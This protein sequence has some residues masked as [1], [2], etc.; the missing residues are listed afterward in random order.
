M[1]TKF[2]R[3]VHTARISHL[4]SQVTF[5]S[6]GVVR[7]CG[8]LDMSK[9]QKTC[10]KKCKKIFFAKRLLKSKTFQALKPFF[11]KLFSKKCL[12]K[13]FY[14]LLWQ[15]QNLGLKMIRI[16]E[17][18]KFYQPPYH[19][20]TDKSIYNFLKYL[21]YTFLLEIFLWFQCIVMYCWYHQN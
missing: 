14:I 5:Q 2:V 10:K 3:K 6:H 18:K 11:N 7:S 21:Y 1:F 19:I 9:V 17:F 4:H 12:H 13:V 16:V 20:S 15:Q 8:K